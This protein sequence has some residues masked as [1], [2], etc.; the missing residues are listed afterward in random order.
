MRTPRNMESFSTAVFCHANISKTS[1]EAQAKEL[2]GADFHK[3]AQ[4]ILQSLRSERIDGR[5]SL[6]NAATTTIMQPN[7]TRKRSSASIVSLEEDTKILP[8]LDTNVVG[9]DPK[10]L[11]LLSFPMKL[12]WMLEDCES[13]RV[14]RKKKFAARA[15]KTNALGTKKQK[16]SGCGSVEDKII[17]GWLPGGEAFK[18]YDEER[19]VREVM[20]TYFLG[21]SIIRSTDDK[22]KS[23]GIESRTFEDFRKN[24]ELWGFTD[25]ISVGGPPTRR[26]H[27]CSHP[28][29]VRDQPGACRSMRFVG[30]HL[31]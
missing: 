19:F 8:I 30:T 24:L 31:P 25:M 28:Q 27:I 17:I 11:L 3:K 20:P 6:T 5:T 1:A 23:R 14:K 12:H 13:Q 9:R 22:K 4:A 15:F 18:I 26:I 7:V 2:D 29:F 21:S 16:K 10:G